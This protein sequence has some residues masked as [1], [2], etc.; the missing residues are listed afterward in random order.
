MTTTIYLKGQQ[1]SA[2]IMTMMSMMLMTVLGLA[3]VFSASNEN[4]SSNSE[5]LANQA[6]YAA[7]AGLDEA[8]MVLRGNRV[9]LGST[10]TSE[11]ITQN[12]IN[13]QVGATLSS[14]NRSTDAAT[15]ARLSRWLPYSATNV[16]ASDLTLPNNVTAAGTTVRPNL[17]G[18]FPA[19][20]NFIFKLRRAPCGAI[21]V[22]VI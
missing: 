14:S 8:V 20:F 9:P 10:N 15:F 22:E 7:E 18:I 5:T 16:T 21:P 3:L 19:S 6:Y 11:T 1:G 4:L 2:L 13:L 12:Q 17:P